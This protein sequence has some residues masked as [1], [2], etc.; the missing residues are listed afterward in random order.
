MADVGE[1]ALELH[2]MGEVGADRGER[3]LEVDEGLLR[4]G[5]EVAGRTDDLVVEVEAELA[6]DEDDAARHRLDH[7]GVADGLRDRIG[8]EKLV[9]RHG[10]TPGSFG[11]SRLALNLRR[12]IHRR[13]R[14]FLVMAGLVPATPIMGHGRAKQSGSPGQARR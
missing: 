6:G 5:A 10:G 8:V 3:V 1:V 12:F 7:M 4:L 14:I 11:G 2:D 9:L 13:S